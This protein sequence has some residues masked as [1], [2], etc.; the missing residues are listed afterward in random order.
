MKWL[1]LDY[2]VPHSQTFVAHWSACIL[3]S[4]LTVTLFSSVS[5]CFVYMT[6]SPHLSRSLFVFSSRGDL[7]CGWNSATASDLWGSA[8]VSSP[9]TTNNSWTAV[10]VSAAVSPPCPLRT[11]ELHST[12]TNRTISW[13]L[14]YQFIRWVCSLVFPAYEVSKKTLSSLDSRTFLSLF[15]TSRIFNSVFTSF[16]YLGF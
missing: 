9:V 15:E 6:E 11:T 2:F 7:H 10:N 3:S 8:F 1:R 12:C 16:K 5:L 13:G 4:F 14:Y